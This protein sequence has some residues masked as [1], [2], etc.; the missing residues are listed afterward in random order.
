MTNRIDP[1]HAHIAAHLTLRTMSYSSPTRNENILAALGLI[2]SAIPLYLM[3]DNPDSWLAFGCALA[4][5]NGLLF[6]ALSLPSGE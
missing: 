2:A 6:F 3:C 1:D 5:L 4:W